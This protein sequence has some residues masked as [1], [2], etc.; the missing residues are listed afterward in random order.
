MTAVVAF[1]RRML[2]GVHVQG[3]V[4][5]R[6]C[7][8]FAANAPPVVKINDSVFTGKQRRNRADLYARSIGAVIAPHNREQPPCVRERTLFNVLDP[9]AIDPDRHLMLRLARHRTGV[10]ADTLPVIDDKAEIHRDG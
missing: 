6:L 10:A 2:V 7:A 4:G 3:V 1:C 8:R 9:S 5:T